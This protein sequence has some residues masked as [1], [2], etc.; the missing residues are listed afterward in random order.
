MPGRIGPEGAMELLDSPLLFVRSLAL[1]EGG[2]LGA[3]GERQEL[4]A[5]GNA[6]TMLAL[7]ATLPGGLSR[8]ALAVESPTGWILYL[9]KAAPEGGAFS[10]AFS[11]E[12]GI[13][14]RAELG[15][16]KRELRL[17]SIAAE[18]LSASSKPWKYRGSPSIR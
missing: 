14:Y 18:S 7:S 4:G 13:V 1:R 8:I 6:G 17:T 11:G 15:E 10:P 9:Q 12:E 16:G 5:S 3:K 2:G